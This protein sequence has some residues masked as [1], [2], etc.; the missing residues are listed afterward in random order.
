M[1]YHQAILEKTVVGSA[2]IMNIPVCQPCQC[3]WNTVDG[4]GIDNELRWEM[5]AGVSSCGT[6]SRSQKE[7][8]HCPSAV[9]H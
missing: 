5:W 3:N 1:S 9:G 4:R 6:L 7:T 2:E 8:G